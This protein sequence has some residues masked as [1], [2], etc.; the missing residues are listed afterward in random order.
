MNMHIPIELNEE[1]VLR[2]YND[3]LMKKKLS[4]FF[5]SDFLP[6]KIFTKES[7]GKDSPEIHFSRSKIADYSSAIEYLY[8]QLHCVHN[9]FHS[10][11]PAEGSLNYKNKLWTR[12]EA[13]LMSFYYLGVA[14]STIQPFM[15]EKKSN[16][17]F[18]ILPRI[19][20]T[21]SPN[22]PNFRKKDGQEPADD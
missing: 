5:S 22:D 10:L 7:C 3:C 13:T 6:T 20:P 18:V 15:R 4:A 2:I 17:I 8:G 19:T 21:L 12:N 9:K 1:N 16:N 14:N 11:T